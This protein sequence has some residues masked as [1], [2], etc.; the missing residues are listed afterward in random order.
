MTMMHN[1]ASEGETERLTWW[2]HESKWVF[3]STPLMNIIITL[4]GEISNAKLL[5]KNA[6]NEWRMSK[7]CEYLGIELTSSSSIHHCSCVWSLH[8]QTH[9]ILCIYVHVWNSG[10]YK[11]MSTKIFISI[12][13]WQCT[14]TAREFSYMLFAYKCC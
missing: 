13:F 7:K 14:R 8:I 6:T 2:W 10:N 12:R 1:S 9:R 3:K 4:N 5:L 11:Q